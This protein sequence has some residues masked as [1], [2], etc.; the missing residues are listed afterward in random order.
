MFGC[1]NEFKVNSVVG[2]CNGTQNF[3]CIKINAQS[4]D[5]FKFFFQYNYT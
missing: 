5:Q 4:K 1:F 3:Y 2:F